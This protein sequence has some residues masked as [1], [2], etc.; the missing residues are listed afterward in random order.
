MIDRGSKPIGR[1]VATEILPASPHQFH[2]WTPVEAPLGIGAIVRVDGTDGRVV[3][4]VVTDA[5]AYSDLATPL[6]DV[7]AAEGNPTGEAPT[8]RAEVRLWTAAVLRQVPEEPVQPV[9]RAAVRLATP[10]D[11]ETALRM[12]AFLRGERP[13]GVP[14]G[15]YTAGGLSSLVCSPR[16]A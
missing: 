11:V 1:V 3:H 2:F 13:T 6:H 14:V 4:A 10:E 5:R 16:P 15:L 8:S 12:D 7:L 9:P